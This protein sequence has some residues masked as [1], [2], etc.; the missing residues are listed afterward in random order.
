[1][2]N[3]RPQTN[4]HFEAT[5][6][7]CNIVEPDLYYFSTIFF[8]SLYIYYHRNID[9]EEGIHRSA[10]KYIKRKATALIISEGVGNT[11]QKPEGEYNVLL[12]R[13]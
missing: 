7:I 2:S 5:Y 9:K 6:S 8:T 4:F 12:Y 10:I 11:V 3:L 1:V 13:N